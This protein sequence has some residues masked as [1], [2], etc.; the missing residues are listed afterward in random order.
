MA[1]LFQ[2]K[3]HFH[4]RFQ[5]ES[6]LLKGEVASELRIGEWRDKH[7]VR[8]ALAKNC[9]SFFCPYHVQN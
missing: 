5:P 1:R 2:E 7:R 9:M 4:S 8:L 3:R 6:Q